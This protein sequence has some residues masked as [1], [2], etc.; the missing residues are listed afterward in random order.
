[1]AFTEVSSL[2]L[3]PT[4]PPGRILSH[5]EIL[6]VSGYYITSV[7]SQLR[8]FQIPIYSLIFALVFARNILV[9]I[10]EKCR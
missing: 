2:L 6:P 10:Q 7:I 8:I 3:A 4:D 9:R 5:V 1:M